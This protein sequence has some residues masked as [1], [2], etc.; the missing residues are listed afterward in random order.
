[1][2]KTDELKTEWKSVR[3]DNPRGTWLGYPGLCKG[4]GLCIHKC[5]TKVI[6]WSEELGVYGTPRV[7]PNMEGCIVCGM[8]QMVCPDC[9]IRIEKKPI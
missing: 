4:C 5:P 2:G 1:M 3:Y 6:V 7:K 9:A 8:C